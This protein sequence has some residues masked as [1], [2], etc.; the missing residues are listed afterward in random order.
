MTALFSALL[1]SNPSVEA[2]LEHHLDSLEGRTHFLTEQLRPYVAKADQLNQEIIA[3]SEEVTKKMALLNEMLPTLNLA[4]KVD[5]DFQ[6]IDALI[7]SAV[8]SIEQQEIADR[9]A[10]ICERIDSAIQE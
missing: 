5:A 6:Q 1:L 9:I 10:A 2:I 3:L 7:N 4:L 8:L